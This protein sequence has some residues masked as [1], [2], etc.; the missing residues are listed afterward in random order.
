MAHQNRARM[1]SRFNARYMILELFTAHSHFWPLA[2]SSTPIT[3]GVRLGQMTP[4]VKAQ[5]HVSGIESRRHS[6]SVLVCHTR[7]TPPWF[8][9]FMAF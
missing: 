5:N 4:A 2:M 1:P 7:Y 8:C 9:S 6:S 3:H